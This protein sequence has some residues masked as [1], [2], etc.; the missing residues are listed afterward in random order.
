MPNETMLDGSALD[1]EDSSNGVIAAYIFLGVVIVLAVYAYCWYTRCREKPKT[2][3]PVDPDSLERA[4]SSSRASAASI[5]S[6]PPRHPT[7]G[8]AARTAIVVSPRSASRSH[9]SG[10]IATANSLTSTPFRVGFYKK[11]CAVVQDTTPV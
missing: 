5:H 2:V 3:M 10:S 6:T 8:I 4:R 9:G 7:L 1:A 11:P